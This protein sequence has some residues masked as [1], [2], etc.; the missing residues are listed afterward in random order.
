ML[1]TFASCGFAYEEQI[2]GNYYVISGDTETH[3]SL[4]YRLSSGDYIGKAPGIL[5]EYGHNDTFLVAKTQNYKDKYPSYYIIDMSED[6]ELAHE[7]IFRVGPINEEE[8]NKTWKQALG[9]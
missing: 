7:E 4:S 6:S 5:L 9:I 8:Y 3:L 2:T 1:F